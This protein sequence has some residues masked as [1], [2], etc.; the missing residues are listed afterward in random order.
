LQNQDKTQ[1]NMHDASIFALK[2]PHPLQATLTLACLNAEGSYPSNVEERFSPKWAICGS[3]AP[4]YVLVKD[5][6]EDEVFDDD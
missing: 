1:T 2:V 5:C 3:L 4:A 6:S